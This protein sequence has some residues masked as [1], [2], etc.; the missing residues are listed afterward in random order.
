M[1]AH[2]W[3]DKV[4]PSTTHISL[5]VR[6]HPEDLLV[7]HVGLLLLSVV[8]G[9]VGGFRGNSA[10]GKHWKNGKKKTHTLILQ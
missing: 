3:A 6:D 1:H 10:W 8:F 9:S 4:Q 5:K 2:D 7:V